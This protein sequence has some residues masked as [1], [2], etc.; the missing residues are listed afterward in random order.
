FTI[1]KDKATRTNVEKGVINK[2]VDFLANLYQFR[3][4]KTRGKDQKAS[5]AFDAKYK[6]FDAL[7]GKF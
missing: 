6:E 2:S 4:N 7:H 1:L 5:D 3:T